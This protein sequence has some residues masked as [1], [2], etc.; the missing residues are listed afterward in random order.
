MTQRAPDFGPIMEDRGRLAGALGL[1]EDD[2]APDL[3]AQVVSTG[4]PHFM[5]PVHGLDALGRAQ[6]DSRALSEIVA[7]LGVRWAYLF[8]AGP[9][10][11]TAAARARLLGGGFEDA[12]TGSAAG[13]LG[14]YLVHYGL[15]RPG[16][17]DIEQGIEMGRPSRI[18]VDVRVEAGQI[19]PVRVS[20]DVSIWARGDLDVVSLSRMLES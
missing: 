4:L 16:L 11:T 3:P 17:M 8:A 12:A 15:H 13:P 10:D 5:V 20:G 14:A 1:A 18:L 6:V 19:G 7:G 2:L 9:P